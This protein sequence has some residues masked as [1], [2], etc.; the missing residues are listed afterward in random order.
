M[1][2]LLR[3]SSHGPVR[4]TAHWPVM[5]K[6]TLVGVDPAPPCVAVPLRNEHHNALSLGEFMASACRQLAE[7][8]VQDED[9]ASAEDDFWVRF[10]TTQT[11]T[12]T[13]VALDEGYEQMLRATVS[14]I[15]TAEKV[16]ESATPEE[17]V[18]K[19]ALSAKRRRVSRDQ[20]WGAAGT[21]FSLSVPFRT[22]TVE[23]RPVLDD[24]DYVR[25]GEHQPER[26]E[27]E[28]HKTSGPVQTMHADFKI[29]RLFGILAKIIYSNPSKSIKC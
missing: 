7:V 22:R 2:V 21:K 29:A 1:S 6:V 14:W 27:K 8:L 17:S 19:V 18:A 23:R 15:V 10:S 28:W 20:V 12:R 16:D 13:T 4:L 24:F 26:N 11:D 3:R 25:F 9:G 5:M